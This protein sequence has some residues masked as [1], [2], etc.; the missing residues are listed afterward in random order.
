M[1][2]RCGTAAREKHGKLTRRFP[3]RVISDMPIDAGHGL[4]TADRDVLPDSRA[5]ELAAALFGVRGRARRLD[6]EYDEN[7]HIE[8]AGGDPGWVLKIAQAGEDEAVIALQNEAIRHVGRGRPRLAIAEVNG[9]RRHVRLLDW[10]PGTL[11]ANVTPQSAALLRSLG[12]EL[13]RLDRGLLDFD[14]PAAH[15]HMQW[16]LLRAGALRDETHHV[17]DQRRRALVNGILQRVDDEIL[18]AVARL[19][20]SVIH[21]DAN[22]F[23]VIERD[24][25]VAGIIDFGDMV[26]SAT[27][28]DLAIAAAYV[29]TGKHDPLG[30]AAHVVAGYARELPLTEAERRALYPLMLA[31]LCV[32][33]VIS[34]A[35]RARAPDVSYYTVHE[36]PA[37]AVLEQLAD[38]PFD[39]AEDVLFS[40]ADDEPRSAALRR[41][42]EERLGPNLSLSYAKPLHIVRGWKQYLY[43]AGG[44]EYLDAYNNVAHVGHSHPR[45]ARAAARQM[46]VLNTNTRYLHDAILEYAARLTAR[47][48]E[49]L[50]VCWFVNSGSEANELA[51]RLARAHSGRAGVIVNEGAYHGN[52]QRL[53]EVSPYKF[54]GPG[55]A[56]PGLGVHVV[57]IP[58]DYRGPFRR[59]DPRAGAKYAAQVRDEVER[60]ATS[61]EPPGA[62]LVESLPSVAGQIVPPPGYFAGAFAAVR[63]AGGV[64]I[65]DEVQ[66]GFGRTGTHFWGF[67]RQG[68][69]P[70]IVVMGKPIGNGHP[71][72]A[73]VTTPEIAKSFANGM[74]F[75]STFGG[76]PVSMAVGLAVLDVL[77]EEQLQENARRVGTRL[78]EQLRELGQRHEIVGD[79]R[80]AG[81]FIGVE[82]VR[83]RATLAPATVETA[84]VVEALK[85]RGI[86]TGTE[87]PHHNVIKIRPPLC[88]SMADADRLVET[89]AAV[90]AS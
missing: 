90:L 46:A 67:E 31:R 12:A 27:V 58:D 1:M 73:V 62:L 15:R 16:D 47:L 65:V 48:P 45:V 54:D 76:N 51:L 23:N 2:H 17:S 71:I 49:P 84:R 80:G 88:I 20:R 57:P 68:V 78:M 37:W 64:C 10:I 13:A 87:G 28:T 26:H 56:G 22:D 19:R 8:G 86:L 33:V 82:L 63:G 74:E 77:D 52:T 9:V 44:R 4:A 39:I 30:A 21:G 5:S 60:A 50:R 6:G 29:M 69:V 3:E 7:F 53:V 38:V 43:D 66:V 59:D 72:G 61:G 18:P 70:D 11:L 36:A 55:G 32:S 83:D 41:E 89:L 34:A 75:F 35:R 25:R 42:R 40:A 79:V 85:D 81:L 14:H 24:D